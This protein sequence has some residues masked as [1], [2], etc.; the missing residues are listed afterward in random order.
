MVLT[1]CSVGLAATSLYTEKRNFA[2]VILIKHTA[3]D[4]DWIWILPRPAHLVLIQLNRIP[5]NLQG[6]EGED[7][8]LSLQRQNC[9]QNK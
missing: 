9:A 6:A 3:S 5:V 8:K 2:E 7:V 4:C 1:Y